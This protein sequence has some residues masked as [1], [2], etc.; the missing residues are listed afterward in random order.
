MIE[1]IKL[2]FNGILKIVKLPPQQQVIFLC[3][4]IIFSVS[5]ASIKLYRKTESNNYSIQLERNE[6][7]S[8]IK[9]LELKLDSVYILRQ[10]E[11][12]EY[13]K[14][15]ITRMDSLLRESEKI[16]TSIKPLV[17]NINKKINEVN[18]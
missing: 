5:V 8:T 10:Q 14:K 11:K 15:E 9:Q 1:N 3:L 17:K 18:N 16:K 12:E 7:K 4:L 13:L 6:Y 2:F